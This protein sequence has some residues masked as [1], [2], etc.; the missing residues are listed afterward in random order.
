MLRPR[1]LAYLGWVWSCRRGFGPLKAALA[2][3]LKIIVFQGRGVL[4]LALL[5][6]LE[7]SHVGRVYTLSPMEPWQK[8][9]RE[10]LSSVGEIVALLELDPSLFLAHPK[11]RM[12]LP[13]RLVAKME[14]GN[15]H[16]PLL[17][18]F[19]PFTAEEIQSPGFSAD[20]VGDEAARKGKKLLQK[21]H[22]RALLLLTSAC[23]MNCRFCFRQNF[24]YDSSGTNYAEELA[25]VRQD[26][27]ITE[28]IL[29]GGDPLALSNCALKVLLNA[30]EEIPHV[31]K[32]RL[33]TRFP[34]GIP[35]RIDQELLTMLQRSR[36]QIV[37]VLHINHPRELDD[38]LF[39]RLEPIQRLGIPLLQQGVLLAGVND[40]VEVLENLYQELTNH[41]IIPYYLHQL[42]RVQGGA[43]FEV[44]VGKGL[45]L[46]DVLRRRLPGYAVPRYVR[47]VEGELSKIPVS[48]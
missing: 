32:I 11:F 38:E 7:I 18:Q 25:L 36:A 43:H 19:L 44:P 15:S 26:P 39:L 14:R 5:I 17:R 34:I 42:D 12:N 1:L 10:N 35:E 13:R 3:C 48:S 31:S 20:P 46:M 30:L 45:Q 23:A 4:Q 47:E 8:I 2:T 9:F 27:S 16:D 29:S 28:V 21:Y 22:G 24:D 33:H 6:L 40:S 37:I 41:G